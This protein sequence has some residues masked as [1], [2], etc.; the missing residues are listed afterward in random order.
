MEVELSRSFVL[1]VTE[2]TEEQDMGIQ[3]AADQVEVESLTL[4]KIEGPIF[5]T[6]LHKASVTDDLLS[7]KPLREEDVCRAIFAAN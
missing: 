3:Q 5:Q 4:S 1:E 7:T 2:I 6:R